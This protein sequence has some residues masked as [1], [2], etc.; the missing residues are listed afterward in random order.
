MGVR[1]YQNL[2]K[3]CNNAVLEFSNKLNYKKGE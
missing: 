1:F 2:K 3:A